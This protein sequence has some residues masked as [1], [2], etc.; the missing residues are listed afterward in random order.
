MPD[1][2]TILA[3]TRGRVRLLTL[4]RP[5]AMNALNRQMAREL[6]SAAQEA[7]T[8]PE[9]GCLVVTGSER[10]FAAGADI[11]EMVTKDFATMHQLDWFAEWESFSAIRKPIIA[12]VSGHALGGGCELALMCDFIIAAENVRFGQPEIKLGVMPAMGGSQRLARLIGQSKTMDMCLTGRT[13]DASEA[14][15]SGLVARV[16]PTQD[17]LEETIRAAE[18][19]AAMSLPAIMSIKDAVRRAQD[20]ALADGVRYERRLFHAL[21][22]TSDQKE[23]MSAFLEKRPATFLHR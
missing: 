14:E 15:R 3:E 9:I 21:F 8:D 10:A 2:E 22:A 5:Q 18:T 1:H 11:R 7:D 4:N 12:A 23:G 17:L 6:I 16:V 13:L 19:I 20:V